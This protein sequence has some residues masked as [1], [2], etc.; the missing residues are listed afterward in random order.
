MLKK[1]TRF[2]RYLRNWFDIIKILTDS[3]S[4]GKG[5]YFEKKYIKINAKTRI[6]L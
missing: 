6:H 2:C 4:A 5:L 1:S 3:D